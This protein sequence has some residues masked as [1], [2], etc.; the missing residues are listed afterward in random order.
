MS[1]DVA[2]WQKDRTRQMRTAHEGSRSGAPQRD[3]P[4]D[5]A[6]PQSL[7]DNILH[8]LDEAKAEEVVS[9][10][11]AGKSTI[12][13]FMVVASGRSDRHVSAIGEQIQRH[14]KDQGFGRVRIEGLDQGDWVLIDAGS[15]IVHVFRPEVREF[16][17]LERMWSGERP[18]EGPTH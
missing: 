3:V 8:W 17:K 4:P 15:V 9:I 5:S 12:A 13:D 18:A 10:D 16:Y 6:S 2:Q 14:L 11:L 1:R 7:L